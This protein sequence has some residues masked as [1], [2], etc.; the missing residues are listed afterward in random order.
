MPLSQLG[1]LDEVEIRDAGVVRIVYETSDSDFA[2]VLCEGPNGQFTAVGEVGGIRPGERYHLRGRW[3]EHPKY[4]RQL[5]VTLC[6]PVPPDGREALIR[7]LASTVPG[8]GPELAQHIADTLGPRA[9]DIIRESPEVLETVPGIGPVRA[10]AIHRVVENLKAMTDVLVFLQGAGCSPALARR[11]VEI[12]GLSAAEVVRQ[13]PYR[14]CHDIPGVGFLT[15]DRIARGLG[16]PRESIART[17]AAV[18]H[19][20]QEAVEDGHCCL[21]REEL[22]R[23]AT[24]ALGSE[25]VNID[26]ALR[27][28]TADGQ[29]VVEEGGPGKS[30]IYPSWVHRAELRAAQNLAALLASS[31]TAPARDDVDSWLATYESYAGVQL[32]LQQKEAIWTAV[33]SPV[34]IITGPPGVGKTTTLRALVRLCQAAGFRIALACPTGRAAQRLEE[35]TGYQAS[36]LHKLLGYRPDTG[37]FYWNS[38]NPLDTDIVVVDESSMLDVYLL[39]ALTSAIR[40][41]TRLV[42]VGDADQLPPVGPGDVLRD[43]IRSGVI[44]TVRLT[45]VFRQALSSLIVHN[46]HRILG[47]QFLYLPRTPGRDVLFIE[48]VSPDDVVQSVVRA[49]ATILPSQGFDPREDVQVLAPMYRGDVGI[50][51]LNDALRD[52]LNPPSPDRPELTRGRTTFRVGDRVVQLTNDYGKGVMNGDLGIITHIDPYNRS[53]TV[54]YPQGTVRYDGPEIGQLQP[55]WALSVHKAQGGEYPAVVIVVDT[56]HY[57]MLSRGLLYTALTRARKT[58]VLVGTKRAIAMAIRNTAPHTRYTS[59]AEKLKQ[60]AGGE[61]PWTSTG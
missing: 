5:Q 1:L 42:L 46:A 54:E 31:V 61:P 55:A 56:H 40:P 45:H 22:V 12:Y 13:N 36:T 34:S 7:F 9:L 37:R 59:L 4:G 28:L 24:A 50:H 16:V 38:E 19:V 17:A 57:V 18:M 51:R 26:L 10:A 2:V 8:V 15:A 53:L 48:A 21:P 6:V 20:L 60:V 32:T 27:K 33:S 44:P 52:I 29:I 39:S 35:F 25:G 47:G 23:R 30:A 14:L 41:G 43:L 3:V 49:V 11:I 58:A